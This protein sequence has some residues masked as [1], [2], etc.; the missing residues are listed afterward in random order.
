MGAIVFFIHLI[1]VFVHKNMNE[2]KHHR[3]L[4]SIDNYIIRKNFF[5]KNVILGCLIA[6]CVCIELYCM[7][8]CTLCSRNKH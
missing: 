3:T 1:R 8:V 7:F 4:P 2:V 6:V 5:I